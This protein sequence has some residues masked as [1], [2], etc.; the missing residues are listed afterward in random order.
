MAVDEGGVH[1]PGCSLRVD[2]QAAAPLWKV[3]S[4]IFEFGGKAVFP[5]LPSSKF[6]TN[7]A[8]IR[9]ALCA[10]GALQSPP[11]PSPGPRY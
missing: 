11:A 6:P 9:I 10:M 7:Q 5:M 8:P 3:Q 1:A 2:F 4:M